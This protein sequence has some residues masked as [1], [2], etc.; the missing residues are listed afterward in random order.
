L[1]AL[2]GLVAL[3]LPACQQEMAQQPAFRKFEPSEFFPKD[4]RSVRPILPGTVARNQPLDYEPLVNGLTP[5]GRRA[6]AAPVN[7]NAPQGQPNPEPGT[8]SDPANYVNAF[9]FEIKEADLRRGQERFTIFCAPCHGPLGN[10][11]GKI[12]ERGY[13]K[14]PSYVTDLSRGFQRFGKQVPLRDAPVGYYYEVVSRGYG[15]MPD[16]AAQVAPEDRWKIIAYV[17]ALVLSQS[18]DVSK[19]PPE[20]QQAADKALGG[21]KK[22]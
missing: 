14:P 4:R 12:A 15:G 10:G 5:E 17:R 18:A 7:P 8:P 3:A 9:P 20:E 1:L 19:L 11:Q 16:Y 6:K 2:L 22:P 13:L 21:V